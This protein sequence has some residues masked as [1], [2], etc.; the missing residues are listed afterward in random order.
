MHE[1]DRGGGQP[2]STENGSR[3]LLGV[4]SAL[5]PLAAAQV[6]VIHIIVDAETDSAGTAALNRHGHGSMS[7]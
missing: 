2:V 5:M 1:A 6:N 3:L 7:V 4:T